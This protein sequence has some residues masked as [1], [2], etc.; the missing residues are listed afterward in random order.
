VSASDVSCTD[1]NSKVLVVGKG[2]IQNHE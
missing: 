2:R 1:V